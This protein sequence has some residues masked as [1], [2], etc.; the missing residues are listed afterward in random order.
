MEMYEQKNEVCVNLEPRIFRNM[1]RDEELKKTYRIFIDNAGN[2]NIEYVRWL[3]SVEED[4]RLSELVWDELETIF[5]KDATKS[6]NLLVDIVGITQFRT[7]SP[8]SRKRY[9]QLGS[10]R[11]IK[12]IALVGLNPLYKTAVYFMAKIAGKIATTGFF[13]NRE[14]A[15]TWLKGK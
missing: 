6:Y 1:M 7:P 15:L 9:L 2:L 11:Q 10:H 3:E 13:N 14:Q 5:K 8:E 12:K 4:D